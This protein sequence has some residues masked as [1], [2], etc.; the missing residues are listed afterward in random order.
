MADYS[1]SG[2]RFGGFGKER[3]GFRFQ[4][5][6]T[7]DDGVKTTRERWESSSWLSSHEPRRDHVCRPVIIG[8]DGKASPVMLD[9][10]HHHK[11]HSVT[12]NGWNKSGDTH[13]SDAY[14]AQAFLS[15]V[16]T[17]ASDGTRL[18]L[19]G[20]M[21]QR[22]KAQYGAYDGDT[23]YKS[24]SAWSGPAA[25]AAAEPATFNTGGW[26]APAQ[27]GKLSRA[28]NDIGTAAEFLRESATPAPMAGSGSWSL[29][30]SQAFQPSKKSSTATIDSREAAKKYGGQFIW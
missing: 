4:S 8:S 21:F 18:G 11:D 15:N 7:D 20:G 27:Q 6:N 5:W 23:Y 12:G 13:R 22:P 26:A 19:P 16:Q 25:A 30:S 29:Q 28:T 24:S 2:G 3:T 14:E 9:S 1:S 17:A 10:P